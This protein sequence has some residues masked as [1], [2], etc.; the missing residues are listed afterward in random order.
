[1]LSKQLTT[2][3]TLGRATLHGNHGCAGARSI[4][5]ETFAWF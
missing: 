3:T 1:M 2:R 5:V 4:L